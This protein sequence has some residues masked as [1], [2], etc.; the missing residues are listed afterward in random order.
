LTL[1][2]EKIGTPIGAAQLRL[3]NMSA[4][5]AYVSGPSARTWSSETVPGDVRPDADQKAPL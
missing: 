1:P 5:T 4:P 2:V 3:R